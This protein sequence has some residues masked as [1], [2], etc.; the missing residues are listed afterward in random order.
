MPV[1]LNLKMDLQN[2]IAMENKIQLWSAPVVSAETYN[3]IDVAVNHSDISNLTEQ[4][5]N[6]IIAAFQ[7][8]AYDMATGYTWN[9]A[10]IKLKEL[11]GSLGGDFISDML[12]RN[13]IN[14]FSSIENAL[15]DVDAILLSEKLGIL[16]SEGAMQLR[17]AKEQLSFYF[18]T[19]AEEQGAQLDPIH[20]LSI[21]ADSVKHIL[22]IES[23]NLNLE[24][25]SFKQQ[26]LE[27]SLKESDSIYGRIIESSLF[28]LRT[29]CTILLSSIK[30]EKGAHVENASANLI[31]ILPKI[32][33]KLSDE[34]KWN[35]GG[36]YKDVV[37]DGNSVATSSIRQALMK[38]KGFDYVPEN[39]RSETFKKAAQ[40]L[41]D[42]H[43]NFNNFYNEPAAVNA[44]AS[45]GTVIPKP[46]FYICIRAF[47]LSYLGNSYGVSMA[48]QHKV[49]EELEKIHVDRWI[50]FWKELIHQDEHVLYHLLNE[51]QVDRMRDLM[52]RIG[53]TEIQELQPGNK[54]LFDAIVKGQKVNATQIANRLYIKLLG[55]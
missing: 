5:K 16:S 20:A 35:I 7:A 2:F 54:H 33:N 47:L 49:I 21:I 43:Y 31:T 8:G 55:R 40:H 24:F 23:G 29:V 50:Y 6:Q 36:V 30:K 46:A 37:A 13:D 15:S 4:Q 38:V 19:Q 42:V 34:D 27:N 45:L 26:L 22:S 3:D 12:Q 41:I 44:L 14:E 53:L 25:S 52:I 11:L 18:S 9:K 17:H 28:Y 48:A 32:W 10:M 39:L 51:S 1:S